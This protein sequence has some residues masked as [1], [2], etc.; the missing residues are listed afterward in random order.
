MNTVEQ[1]KI[2]EETFKGTAEGNPFK[3]VW[4][5]A[6]FTNDTDYVAV[7]GFY[8]GNGEYKIRFMPQTPGVWTGVTESNEPE[9]AGKKMTLECTPACKDNHGRVLRMDEVRPQSADTTE[10]RFHFAYEDG[11]RFQPFGTTCYAWV[12]QTKE[13]QEQTLETLKNAPFNKVRM[14]I[15][16]KHYTYNFN[17]PEYHAF[18]G[19]AKNGFD[20]A[21]FNPVFWENLEKRIAQLDELGIEADIILLHPYDRWGFA[22]MDF[23]TDCYYLKYAIDRLCHFKNVW[24]SL[25]NEFDLLPWEAG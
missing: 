9:L 10:D 2:F 21:R 23:E 1:Y 24:W 4:L 7:N 25:A 11:T 5:K 22:K 15:F 20:F 19:D 12:N 14:C 6:V 13:V 16:P 18:E 17:D 8:D 3:E